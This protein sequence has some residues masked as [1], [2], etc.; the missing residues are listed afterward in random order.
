MAAVAPPATELTLQNVGAHCVLVDRRA[1]VLLDIIDS[2]ILVPDVRPNSVSRTGLV[3]RLRARTSTS[4]VAL[5]APAGYGKTTLLAQWAA[6]DDR[7]FAWVSADERD[8]DAVVLLRHLA[9]SVDRVSPIDSGVF[10]ALRAPGAS[11][12]TSA[13][14]RLARAVSELPEPV[15]VVLDDAHLVRDSDAAD[16]VWAIAE[17]LPAGS[18]LAVAARAAPLLP[19]ASLRA[20]GRL[21]ELRADD[22]AL[23]RRETELLVRGAG[24]E[25]SAAEL[26]E[27]ATQTEGWAVAVSLVALSLADPR[28][29]GNGAGL[30]TPIDDRFVA[31]YLDAEYFS[32]LSPDDLDF[33][34]KTAVL[35]RVCGSLCDA[36]LGVSGSGARL[37]AV[38]RSNLFLVPLDGRRD[39]YRYHRLLREVLCRELA[40]REPDAVSELHTRAADWFETH[41]DRE[42]ALEHANH[43]RDID[44]VARLTSALAL[45]VYDSGRISTV[46]RWVDQ[47]ASEEL[48]ERYPDIA[49][50]GA[51][52]RLLS[53]RTD[54]AERWLAA[55]ERGLESS[56]SA[57]ETVG[58]WLDMLRAALCRD[59]VEQMLVDADCALA[60]LPERSEWRPGALLVRGAAHALTGDRDRADR[61][62][63][64]AA[65]AAERLGLTETR[66][67][68]F[69]ERSLLAGD[70]GDH[71]AAE[72][73]TIGAEGL[74][75]GVSD[76]G[77]ATAAVHL[78]ATARVHLRHGRWDAAQT[79]LAKAQQLTPLLTE[80]VPWLAVQARL[81]LARAYVTLRDA[82]AARELL[83]T[84]DEILERRPDLGSLVD[85]VR[86]LRGTIA[87]MPRL[88]PGRAPGLTG[89]ELRLLPLLATHLSFREI[90][91]KLYV[92]RN[93]IKTQAISVYRK[94]GVSTRSEAVARAGE[95]G[96]IE[97]GPAQGS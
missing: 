16:A 88:Q 53:G 78:A 51:R 49:A 34:R 74:D 96:L 92:S 59:G 68:A 21:L 25:L 42:S 6:R 65:V 1:P 18:V 10:D 64:A 95:L 23:T 43:A 41:G 80:A 50:H 36:V 19:I 9:A 72:A 55:A 28:Q 37:V 84:I 35:D 76:V 15:V 38:E 26:D 60:R 89:A 45:S 56:A 66:L 85:G 48:L 7:P 97:A 87:G 79:Q 69:A 31:E 32:H 29:Q 54:E 47:F 8:D 52:L 63:A 39:W 17:H 93:T 30:P 20:E 94:L 67:L 75:E 27:L 3:N 11:I 4:I 61:D 40:D 73:L 83:A 70:R 14:P 57:S 33:M 5:V 62:L 12:W 82:A 81:E 91:S 24:L 2:K 71:D 77:F 58:P 13:V 90:A 22:L 46:E 86:E 44:R